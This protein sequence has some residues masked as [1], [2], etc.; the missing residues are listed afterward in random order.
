MIDKPS[1]LLSVP[2]KGAAGAHNAEALLAS[3]RPF[4]RMTHRLDQATSGLLVAAKDMDAY[5][6]VQRAFQERRVHKA[7]L[8]VLG[9]RW[10][11]PDAGRVELKTRLDPE[12]RPR[13]V[14]DPVR[15]KLGITNWQLLRTGPLGPVLRFEP[16]TGRTHQL[17]VHAAAPEG[18]G[19]PLRGDRLYGRGGDRLCL[20]ACELGLPHPDGG[21]LALESPAPFIGG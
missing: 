8:G 18:L 11:G 7:Y 19:T 3:R 17:R 15:G 5:R 21:W 13:Q 20:H 16:E 10:S 12:D 4:V 1:G 9:R 6:F 14:V 2:G